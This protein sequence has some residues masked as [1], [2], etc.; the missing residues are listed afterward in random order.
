VSV[1][2]TECFDYERFVDPALAAVPFEDRVEWLRGLAAYCEDA[3]SDHGEAYWPLFSEAENLELESMRKKNDPCARQIAEMIAE[4]TGKDCFLRP[5][6]LRRIEIVVGAGRA[7]ALIE[8]H[9]DAR[10]YTVD[11]RR[12]AVF[13][14]NRISSMATGAA[15]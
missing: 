6:W 12:L 7:M 13:I 5:A 8:A 9:Q 3:L 11:D 14:A 10:R 2:H 1:E 4:D 15:K